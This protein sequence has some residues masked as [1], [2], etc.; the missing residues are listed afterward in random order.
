M[1]S[2]VITLVSVS[3]GL[4]TAICALLS[5]IITQR[6]EYRRARMKLHFEQ[7]VHTYFDLLDVITAL[8]ASPTPDPALLKRYHHASACA[9]LFCSLDTQAA[10]SAFG[11]LLLSPLDSPEARMRLSSAETALLLSLQNDLDH[12]QYPRKHRLDLSKHH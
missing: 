1:L 10:V 11:A 5:P 12:D 3:G 2:S 7:K 9:L 6:G 4:L 8:M